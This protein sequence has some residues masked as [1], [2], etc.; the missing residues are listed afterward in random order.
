MEGKEVEVIITPRVGKQ[1]QH[2]QLEEKEKS[3]PSMAMMM[4]P[5]CPLQH[6]AMTRKMSGS[7]RAELLPRRR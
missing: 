3:S 6:M 5:R 7:A 4:M 1:H 2:Q